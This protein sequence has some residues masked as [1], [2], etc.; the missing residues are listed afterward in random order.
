MDKTDKFYVLFLAAFI[1]TLIGVPALQNLQFGNVTQK[2]DN[3]LT[4]FYEI[5]AVIIHNQEVIINN[6]HTIVED[7]E[8]HTDNEVVIAKYFNITGIKSVEEGSNMTTFRDDFRNLTLP[9]SE[10]NKLGLQ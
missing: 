7:T 5:S 2:L 9:E 6:Q 4:I 3:F 8:I 10:L 1:G